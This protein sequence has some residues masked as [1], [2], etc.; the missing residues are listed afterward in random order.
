MSVSAVVAPGVAQLLDAPH[1]KPW[2]VTEVEVA[3]YAEKFAGA[4]AG[5]WA[6]LSPAAVQGREI[7]INS[8]ACCHEGPGQIFSGTKCN[9]PFPVVQAIAGYNP[10]FFKKYVRDPQTMMAGAMMEAHPHY[11]DPQLEV[12][13]AFITADGKK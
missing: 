5:P 10:D 2:G 11:T 12:L 7:W 9:Q 8:C 1:K 6:A 3:N 4:Y 13:I